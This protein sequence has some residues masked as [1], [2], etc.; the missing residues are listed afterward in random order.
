MKLE[1]KNDVE[2][3]F[4]G[5]ALGQNRLFEGDTDKISESLEYFDWLMK[6]TSAGHVTVED[7]K[8]GLEEPI[9]R[10]TLA[11]YMMQCM[12]GEK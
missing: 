2:A 3:F 7:I 1:F 10:G 12:K 8:K 5:F 4:A 11:K 6:E 9:F